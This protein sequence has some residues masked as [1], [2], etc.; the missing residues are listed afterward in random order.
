[1]DPSGWYGEETLDIE[2]V[3]MTAP[4]ASIVYVG[5]PNSYQDLDAALNHVV[6][7][8]LAQIVSNSYGFPTE[9]LAPGYEKPYT[10]I[11][12]EAAATGVGL[13]FSSGDDGDELETVGI[14]TPDWPA[15]GAFVT[16]VGGTSLAIGS[17]NQRL[18]ETGWETGRDP[19]LGFGTSGASYAA[20]PPG[21]FF[22]GSGGGTSRIVPEPAYQLG[23]VPDALATRW[24]TSH[25]GRVVPDIAALGDPNT[26][27]LVGQ[28]QTFSD[29]TYYD[30]YRIGGTSV[31][32][33]LMAGMM[34]LA[35]QAAGSPHG[36][37]N[38]AIYAQAGGPGLY[39]VVQNPTGQQEA[40]VRV[41][42]NNSES[43]SDGLAYSLRTLDY[44][45]Q[46]TL[47]TTPGY[48]DI[49]GVGTIKGAAFLSAL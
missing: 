33:P 36:F 16:A 17:A 46:T 40:V 11:E 44:P 5:A 4:G 30:E 6:D 37:A 38:P 24:S 20:A 34:A 32:S 41:N 2:A 25:P 26:G 39:D 10:S 29:G 3:H 21:A 19:I 12:I 43:A 22:G 7:R 13:Y 49:T 31:A 48:D 47:A 1:M 28:T 42:Y 8:H 27:L 18:F 23:V 15:S 45:G 35:D 14:A 9:L